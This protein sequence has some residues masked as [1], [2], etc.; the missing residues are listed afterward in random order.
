MACAA[1]IKPPPIRGKLDWTHCMLNFHLLSTDYL[2]GE[3]AVALGELV[4]MATR[5]PQTCLG[6]ES[7]W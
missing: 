3:N 6:A 5:A 1:H 7:N 4:K 2:I